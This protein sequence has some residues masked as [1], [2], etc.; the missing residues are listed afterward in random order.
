[1]VV[2]DMTA[3]KRE[4]SRWKLFTKEVLGEIMKVDGKEMRPIWLNEDGQTVS[5][6]PT[7]SGTSEAGASITVN[8]GGNDYT[9]TADA[10]GDW[11]LSVPDTL[12]DGSQAVTVTAT[13]G[14]GNQAVANGT[15][16]VDGS[17]P[18]APSVTGI[19]DDTGT[20]NSEGLTQ[21]NTLIISGT[22]EANSS[23]EVFVNGG[24][25]GTT[26]ADGSGDWSLDHSGNTL[27]DGAHALTATAADGPSKPS[28]C[29]GW[30]HCW[31]AWSFPPPKPNTTPAAM[32]IPSTAMLRLRLFMI[33]ASGFCSVS[34]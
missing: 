27:S 30:A 32:K 7:L 20:S 4:L 17:A 9:T 19:S 11:S 5:S 31:L 25:I 22:A 26:A 33:L 10:S 3:D 14:A 18:N 28:A 8:V 21:D 34:G 29:R 1:G 13:D 16:T 24:S 6:T 12:A 15:V 2:Y 23:V